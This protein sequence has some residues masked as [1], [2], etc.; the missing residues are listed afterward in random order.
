MTSRMAE[1]PYLVDVLLM[2]DSNMFQP[3]SCHVVSPVMRYIYHT[4]S[5]ASGLE[6]RVSLCTKF[7]RE[8]GL[9]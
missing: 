3:L 1:W 2:I 4:D 9:P 5:I 6:I 8:L 7:R